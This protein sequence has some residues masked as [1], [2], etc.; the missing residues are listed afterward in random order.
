MKKR[1]LKKYAGALLAL[2]LTAALA[3]AVLAAQLSGKIEVDGEADD[4]DQAGVEAVTLPN[5]GGEVKS[6]RA[7][8][9][10]DGTVYLCFQGE[11]A[12]PDPT[13]YGMSI[14]QAGSYSSWVSLYDLT[15]IPGM[16][17]AMV[18]HSNGWQSGPFAQEFSIPAEYFTDPNFVLGYDGTSIPADAIPTLDDVPPAPSEPPV[19][20]GIVIDGKYG[21]WAAVRK[22]EVTD[23]AG[24][25]Q[26]MALVFDGDL[27]IY[28]YESYGSAAGSS[29]SSD[30]RFCITSDLGY[31]TKF[32]LVMNEG[33]AGVAGAESQHVGK[34]WE[35]RI[36]KEQLPPY[37]KSVSIGF[38]QGQPQITDVT[39]LS[40]APGTAGEFSGIVIDGQYGDWLSLPHTAVG[41]GPQE[42]SNYLALYLDG[43]TLYAHASTTVSGILSQKGGP[44]Y[45]G[46]V[47]SFEAGGQSYSLRLA[48]MLMG[49]SV[50]MEDGTRLLELHWPQDEETVCGS[51]AFTING[52]KD[53]M[54]LSL[55]IEK[56]AKKLG[57]DNSDFKDMKIRIDGMG[58][59]SVSFSGASSAPWLLLAVLAPAAILAGGRYYKRRESGK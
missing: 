58:S 24:H 20:D 31:E 37:Q 52:V 15:Q 5:Q 17:Q 55:E 59:Q 40:G 7:A 8:R 34:Q 28:I 50:P 25:T 47:I 26:E 43:A 3:P 22:Q 21:D 2:A 23:P 16:Q 49:V 12:R 54:E 33:V 44:L 48:E 45:N 9:G 29:G 56:L 19:Y 1:S 41:Y 32:Q 42:G 14:Q 11:A 27:Y 39:D 18:C 10:G 30:G 4:W 13:I 57:L 35:I 53:E 46:T 51:V 36:P 6:W 38:E